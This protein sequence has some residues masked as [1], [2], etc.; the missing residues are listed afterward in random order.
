MGSFLNGKSYSVCSLYSGSKGNC[1]LIRS[2]RARILIDAGKSAKALCSALESIG[3]DI[4]NIDAIFITHEHTDHVSALA[5]MLKKHK[6]P[7]HVVG[8]TA[9]KMLLCGSLGERRDCFCIHPPVFSVE[10]GDMTVTSF[11]TSHD[12]EFSVGYKICITKDG[13]TD[14]IGY[15]TDLGYVSDGVREALLGCETVV[16]ESNHDL[17]MLMGG[18]YPYELKIR[19]ASDRGHL[20]NKACALFA[21]ELCRAGTKNILLAHLSEENNRPDVA[22]REVSASIEDKDVNLKIAS[23]YESVLL[24]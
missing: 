10:V 8:A 17:D 13:K 7:V 4:S 20:S 23:A 9:D 24:V 22:F 6:I 15:A 12:S 3:E 14:N 2:E 18:S 16:L 5:V 11:P 1:V 19:I 21:A